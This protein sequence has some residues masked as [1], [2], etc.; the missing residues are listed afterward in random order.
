MPSPVSLVELLLFTIAVMTV[1]S[2]P[3]GAL[4][5]GGANRRHVTR[6]LGSSAESVL[7]T[8]MM[9]AHPEPL[10]DLE[11]VRKLVPP[12]LMARLSV[13]PQWTGQSHEERTTH[14]LQHVGE[15]TDNSNKRRLQW[16]GCC[17]TQAQDDSLAAIAA[18]S[19]G[20]RLHG[21]TDPLAS[22]TGAPETSCA[23]DCTTLRQELF[24]GLPSHC[25]IYDT[26]TQ[27][28]PADLLSRRQQRL[29]TH[30]FVG[31]GAPKLCHLL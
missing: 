8:G 23:Y 22:N 25:F 17:S 5:Q 19:D 11:T 26:S 15:R 31:Q 9:D 6:Q 12:E 21:C 3:A 29:E 7:A 30:T 27:T 20:S 10:V 2:P 18:G 4:P 1:L 14:L 13:P 24:L 16:E 28:W